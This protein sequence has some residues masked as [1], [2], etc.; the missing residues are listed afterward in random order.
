MHGNKSYSIIEP[1]ISVPVAPAEGGREE[2]DGEEEEV[3]GEEG[4]QTLVVLAHHVARPARAVVED[5]LLEMVESKFVSSVPN[6]KF[7]SCDLWRLVL[8]RR[9]L[10][11]ARRI[12]I[13]IQSQHLSRWWNFLG[14]EFPNKTVL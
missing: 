11:Q 4:E 6:F 5:G 7:K 8:P 12:V 2:S 14:N 9:G 13:S 10:L 1:I 3:E